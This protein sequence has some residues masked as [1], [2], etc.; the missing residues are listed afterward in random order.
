V[1]RRVGGF[2][3]VEEVEGGGLVVEAKRVYIT[4]GV[5]C[6]DVIHWL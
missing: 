4:R 6:R 2:E 1:V 5:V 3:T